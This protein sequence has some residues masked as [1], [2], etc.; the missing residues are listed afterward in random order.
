[1]LFYLIKRLLLAG[2]TLSVILLASY[3]LLRCAPG[4]PARSNMFVDEGTG[5]SMDADKGE[6]RGNRAVREKLG[7]DE[8]VL[9]GF[10][11]WFKAAILHGDLG[12]SVVVDPGRPVTRMIAERLPVTL[13]LNC[14]S[15]FF[16]YL[17][18]ILIG[19]YSAKYENS[20]FDRGGALA[21]F[22][23]YSLPVMWVGLLLQALTCEGGVWPI[24]PLKGLNVTNANNMNSWQL[25]L[26]SAKCYILPVLC[27]SYA[28]LA[29]L[30][31]YAR[32]SM[33]EVIHGDFIRTA[34]AK[35]A[36]ETAI[37]WHHAFRNALI[38]LITLFGGLLPGLV[39]GSVLV[40]YIFNIPGMGAL[41]LVALSSRDYPLVM[42]LFAFSGILTLAG[43][44][45]S[46]LLYAAADPRI[47]L[48]GKRG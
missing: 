26:A 39:A 30:S 32:N 1:M 47:S 40:E 19:V 15:V 2:L 18:A 7:L 25:L 24:F 37:L 43:I 14:L 8:P 31:R 22:V 44:L 46:D 5:T 12:S 48:T 13:K 23:L 21:L 42:A 16:T 9:T 41:S 34:R 27:L 11:R 10:A 20:L 4:D 38:T 3:V 28:G 17:L 29:G 6:H 33:L 36:S 45:L 35:G